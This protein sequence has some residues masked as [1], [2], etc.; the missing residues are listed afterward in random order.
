MGDSFISV[1]LRNVSFEVL[2]TCYVR[3]LMCYMCILFCSHEPRR[4]A[5]STAR[6]AQLRFVQVRYNFQSANYM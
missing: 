3:A 1:G 4:F 6:L 5:P 2:S